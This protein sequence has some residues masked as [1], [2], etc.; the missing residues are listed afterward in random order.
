MVHVN[1]GKFPEARAAF[2][3]YLKAAPSGP[4]AAEVK[5]FL[6]QLPK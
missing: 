1:L 3:G 6:A 4:K 5:G 2:E